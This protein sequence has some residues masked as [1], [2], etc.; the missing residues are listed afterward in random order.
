MSLTF[1]MPYRGYQ[2][3]LSSLFFNNPIFITMKPIILCATVLI[4]IHA[5]AAGFTNNPSVTE[6]TR[7][8]FAILFKNASA[9]TWSQSAGTTEAYF[10][11]GH[12]KTRAIFNSK[13]RL[14]Q[15][16]RYAKEGLLSPM[17]F[18]AITLDY[19]GKKIHGVTE[20]SDKNGTLYRVILK[21]DQYYTHINSSH[22]GDI[23]FVTRYK[24]GD[25]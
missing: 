16:T 20:V 11:A 3:T 23:E 5:A 21:D 19:P 6:K 10:T 15:T 13:G 25:L 18:S 24:R 2:D 22:T 1:S 9:I 4:T 17:A 8:N 14:I 7:V 12:I